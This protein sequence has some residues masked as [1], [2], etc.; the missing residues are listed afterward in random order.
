MTVVAVRTEPEDLPVDAARNGLIESPLLMV[1]GLS[2]S[3]RI[4]GTWRQVTSDVSLR[5]EK[6][7]VVGLVG[8]SGSG[9]S[10]TAM[11]ILGLNPRRNYR[12][13]AG[14]IRFAGQDLLNLP[15]GR[16][17]EIRGK[18]ISMIFQDHMTSLNPAMTIGDQVAEVLIRHDVSRRRQARARAEELLDTVGLPNPSRQAASYPHTLSGGM[19][20]RAMIA[21][22]VAC[23]PQLLI[24]DEPTTA[25]DV[26]V[27]AQVLDLLRRLQRELGMAVLFVT[28]DL[29]VVADIC[30]AVYVMYAGHIVEK[31]DVQSLFETPLNPYT[32][33]LLRSSARAGMRGRPLPAIRGAIPLPGAFPPGCRFAPRCAYT[34]DRCHDG[35][36]RLDVLADR[37]QVRC[38]RH[39]EL[40]LRGVS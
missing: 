19:R 34:R 5:I 33:A 1:D 40:T 20:Q 13:D 6:G 18:R 24:A 17:N 14:E 23:S 29:G 36:P 4:D 7:T 26:T 38:V 21:M 9:K 25:L 27:Q 12:V 15:E 28:H 37:R 39:E 32:E 11:S 3:F 30:D 35:V 10:V 31:A 22:A 16:L 8:E 2:L